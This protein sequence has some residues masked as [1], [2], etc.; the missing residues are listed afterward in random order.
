MVA[1]CHKL[2]LATLVWPLSTVN[3]LSNE[4]IETVV[5][6]VELR[7]RDD[8]YW[9]E[10]GFDQPIHYLDHFPYIAGDALRINI[11]PINETR[12]P[13]SRSAIT[14]HPAF[15]SRPPFTLTGI[16]YT[17]GTLELRFSQSTPFFISQGADFRSLMISVPG[18]DGDDPCRAQN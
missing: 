7:Q 16:E 9:I 14:E 12:I 13:Q 6:G 18:P 1:M 5:D 17:P 10:I 8:C 11:K 15:Q 4:L 2:V 3:A